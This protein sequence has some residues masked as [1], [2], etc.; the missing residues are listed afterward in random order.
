MLPIFFVGL[1]LRE[2][3]SH[4]TNCEPREPNLKQSICGI[5]SYIYHKKQPNVGKYPYMDGMGKI[6]QS[7]GPWLM[8]FPSHAICFCE[9]NVEITDEALQQIDVEREELSGTLKRWLEGCGRWVLIWNDAIWESVYIPH[10]FASHIVYCRITVEW[11]IP[12]HVWQR[13]RWTAI[14]SL[15]GIAKSI[16]LDSRMLLW[17]CQAIFWASE[18]V[19][20]RDWSF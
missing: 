7:H 19:T 18:L 11:Y 12:G 17:C 5:I 14:L 6:C 1:L 13:V 9:F 3:K 4:W 15:F 10:I 2:N 8:I 20:W 16:L